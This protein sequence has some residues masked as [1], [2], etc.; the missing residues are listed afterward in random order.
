MS[1]AQVLSHKDLDSNASLIVG[2]I[3]EDIFGAAGQ[4][5]ESEGY[6]SKLKELKFNKSYDTGEILA[7]NISLSA[8]G[9][10]LPVSYTHLDV[11]KRQTLSSFRMNVR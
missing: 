6:T 11:Y 10:L 2:I 8:F 9:A 5:K 3:M 7:A 4:E 1:L